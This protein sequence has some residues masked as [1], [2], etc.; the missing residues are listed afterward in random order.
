MVIDQNLHSA[1]TY[2]TYLF[3]QSWKWTWLHIICIH[4]LKVNFTFNSLEWHEK[5]LYKEN[6]FS[7]STSEYAENIPYWTLTHTSG[8]SL[9]V[10]P[11]GSLVWALKVPM[12]SCGNC[13]AYHVLAL[14][15]WPVHLPVSDTR[16]CL[17][18]EAI[19]CS[20]LY[21]QGVP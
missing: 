7:P 19:L 1:K 2:C 6:M 15:P 5:G 9:D 20:L 8:L 13:S 21:I 11:L 17:V 18:L 12:C 10:P 16:L 4:F 3:L 14:N